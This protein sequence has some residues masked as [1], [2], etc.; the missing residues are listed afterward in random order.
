MLIRRTAAVA[1]LALPLAVLVPAAPAEAATPAQE[2]SSFLQKINAERDARGLADLQWDSKL[3]GTSRS[4]SGV[5]AGN[6][7]LS[8][9]PNLAAVAASVEPSWRS[10]G[11]NVGVG[12]SVTSLHDAF[13]HS[14]GHRANILKPSYNRVGI[15]VVH[16]GWQDLGHRPLPAGSLPLEQ[17]RRSRPPA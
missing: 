6:G 5:M 3:A 8:H 16:S 1:L 4:W 11:E 12:G 14:T 7:E 17:H 2:E 13:M 9:H 15:G 10:V